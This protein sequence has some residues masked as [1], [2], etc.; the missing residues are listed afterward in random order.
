MAG[1]LVYYKC[2][3][4]D[5]LKDKVFNKSLTAG[6]SDTELKIGQ[7][8]ST[9]EVILDVPILPERLPG[10]PDRTDLTVCISIAAEGPPPTYYDPLSVCITDRQKV[11]G[12]Q[13]RDPSEYAGKEGLAPYM[14]VYGDFGRNLT[15][16]KIIE[17]TEKEQNFHRNMW[18]RWPQ[19]FNIKLK[20]NPAGGVFGLPPW[21][22]CSSAVAGGVS[23]SYSYPDK[24]DVDNRLDLVLY[25]YK[26]SETYII[27]MINVAIY[28]DTQ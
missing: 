26:P 24:L 7:D 28:K 13:L 22:L 1:Q 5:F 20:P 27:N 12:V 8:D 14:G 11:M 18:L 21:G 19:M 23:L 6:S 25:R 16:P 10:D 15:N 3:T 2:M 17:S 9:F 4:P